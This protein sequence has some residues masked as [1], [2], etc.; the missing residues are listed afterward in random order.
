M[1][2]KSILSCVALFVFAVASGSAS[3]NVLTVNQYQMNNGNIPPPPSTFNYLDFPYSPDPAGGAT[4]PGAFLFGGTGLLSDGIIPTVNWDAG[5]TQYVGWQNVNP[6]INFIL[7]GVPFVKE[8][9]I[10]VAGGTDNF[11]GLPVTIRVN[12]VPL[13]FTDTPFGATGEHKLSHIYAGPG[14]EGNGLSIELVRGELPGLM[15]SEVQFLSAVPEPSTWAMMI[16]GFAGL[17]FVG[18][19]RQMK[20]AL[21][22]SA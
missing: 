3:A 6:T 22:A 13:A 21:Q 20:V 11:V 18:Y 7:A 9:D 4:T 10:Y 1:R 19:R 15:V 14:F 17:A 12:G 8:L 16:I 2:R 5:P